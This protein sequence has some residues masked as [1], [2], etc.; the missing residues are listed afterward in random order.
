MSRSAYAS[1]R[2]SGSPYLPP[3]PT[4]W[5]D[6]PIWTMF[7]RTVRKGHGDA[8]LLSVYRDH[9]VV[10][11]SSRDDNFNR[12]PEDLDA[13]QLVEP[14]DL[15]V[16]KMKAWQGSLSISNYRGIVS[17]A[18]FIYR[19]RHSNDPRFLHHLL[20]SQP[21]VAAYR[22]I[23]T[24]VRISQWDLDPVAFSRLKIA[25]P[26]IEEQRA[27]ADYLDRETAQID[28]LIAKQERLIDTLRSRRSA[29][30]ERS[31]TGGVN[32]D[33][34]MRATTIAWLRGARVPEHWRTSRLKY[35]MPVM[36]AGETITSDA[37]EPIGEFPV[38]GGNGIRGYTATYT[39]D[40]TFVLIG[41]Q[42]AL[43]GNVHL[44][45]GRFWASEHA[46]VGTP[47]RE[48]HPG[49]LEHILRVMNLGQYSMTSAQP[50]IGVGQISALDVPLPPFRE[51]QAIANYLDE[52]T[53]KIDALI[54]KAQQFIALA[55]ERRAALIT[56]A[57]TG[58]IDVT[59][60]K[61]RAA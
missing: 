5:R 58:Q 51:Q 56:A 47:N 53:A 24:G 59:T 32:V 45:R 26:P 50:G 9:G 44:V 28:T 10:P 49:W 43:C 31:V 39:H 7:A 34:P 8:T 14:G 17:P 15:A 6:T 40:G 25:L 54:A 20:R 11:K 16:N 4:H 60:G 27:I 2:E 18:Y 30:I 1:Y 57:V 41:R 21:M 19:S 22:A 13:Y 12:A 29:V 37:I 35:L 3:P 42:G 38:Y 55:K 52:Q 36:R 23:S 33:S 61:T 48:I 46:I